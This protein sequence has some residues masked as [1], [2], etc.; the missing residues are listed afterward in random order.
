M[1]RPSIRM[2]AVLAVLAATFVASAPAGAADRLATGKVVNGTLVQPAQFDARWRSIAI[3]TDRRYRDT[4]KGQFCGGTFIGQSLV[5]TAA[6]CVFDPGELILFEERGRYTMLN[7][8]VTSKPGTLH[9]VGGRRVLALR[10]GDRIPVQGMLVHPDYDPITGEYDVAL[11]QLRRD[12]R[13]DAV[14]PVSPVPAGE[15]DIWGAGAGTAADAATGPWLAGW[16]W[17]DDP[18][19]YWLWADKL[20]GLTL[21]PSKPVRRPFS[22][23]TARST[24][25][26]GTTARSAANGLQEALVPIR[27]DA[28]C[29][30][31]TPGTGETGYGRDYDSASMLCAGTLDTS[32]Y[33]DA[34]ASTNGVDACYGD[35]GGPLLARRSGGP[36]R[37]VGIVSFGIGCAT[38][39]A[40]GVYTR[41]A[42]VRGFLNGVPP[43]RAVT[44][45]RGPRITNAFA[46][47]FAIPGQVLRCAPGRTFGAGKV[48]SR[49]RWVTRNWDA[50]DSEEFWELDF[51]PIAWERIERSTGR[52]RYQVRPGN[53]GSVI[54]CLEI[55]TNGQ[56]TRARISNQLRVID[57]SSPSFDD[58]DEDDVDS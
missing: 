21:R 19:S 6:H 26:K 2:L 28:Q 17:R 35:S 43:R 20:Q 56:T 50:E 33:N 39:R 27:S 46:G 47:R 16:G 13:T 31:G 32:D 36:L 7:N 57:P 51:S 53:A 9:V 30:N 5:A 58:D 49:W 18:D 40:Y 44:F 8:Q 3:L 15:D 52:R 23:G 25:A 22:T 48:R 10:D 11:I 12:A 34:N 37:L 41:A 1:P 45:A 42:G 54:A 38:S 55:A 24:S 14:T 29:E 4:R